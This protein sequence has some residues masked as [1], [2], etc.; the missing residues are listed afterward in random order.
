MKRKN[1]LLISMLFLILSV[2]VPNHALA[3]GIFE[4]QNMVITENQTVD[5][6]VVL[7]GDAT[8]QGTVTGSVI[9]FNGDLE[10]KSTAHLK[11]IVLVIGGHVHQDH[12]AEMTDEVINLSF[13]NA[14][15]NSLMIGGGLVVG[16]WLLQLAGTVM[17]ILLPT[18][19]ALLSK[20]RI[21]PLIVYA[22][23]SPG[24]TMYIGFFSSLILIAGAVLLLVTIIGI[25]FVVIIILFFLV[26]F[27][28]GLTAISLQVG[29]KIQGSNGQSRWVVTLIGALIVVSGMNIPFVGTVLIIG[30]L[31][32]SIGIMT[33]WIL[34]KLRRNTST[35]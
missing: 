9:V 14:T 17:L 26:S 30:I 31:W 12:G 3:K 1:L 32:F 11:G 23:R 10:V 4:H 27:I 21:N 8:V 7:G 18:L 22:R 29:E 33:M 20:D 19:M 15:Q 28:L 5:D 35:K 25:P 34:K 6:V 16:V 2:F 24:R 13:D